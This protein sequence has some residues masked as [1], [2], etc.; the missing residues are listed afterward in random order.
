M[1]QSMQ[2]GLQ[3]LGEVSR[4]SAGFIVAAALGLN[5]C[6]APGTVDSVD[7]ANSRP[8]VQRELELI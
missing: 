1:Q 3:P 2:P 4:F 5:A 6:G 7:R 8:R